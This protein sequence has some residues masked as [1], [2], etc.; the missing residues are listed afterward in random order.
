M[1]ANES[2][3]P[4]PNRPEAKLPPLPQGFRIRKRPLPNSASHLRRAAPPKTASSPG[5]PVYDPDGYHPPPRAAHTVIIKVTA[6]APFMSL[7]KRV[8]KALDHGPPQ[9]TK[10]LPLTARIA[11]LGVDT[12]KEQQLGPI[13]DALDDVVLIGTGRA[14]QKAVE[15]GCFFARERNL[16]VLPRTRTLAAIDDIEMGDE[17]DA[18]ADVEDGVRVRNVSCIEVGIRWR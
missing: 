7:V 18:D 12:R 13:A 15:V 2:K 11:A 10:G 6:K 5:G 3:Q 8:R 1:D 4:L 14:I 16:M 9:K 17:D